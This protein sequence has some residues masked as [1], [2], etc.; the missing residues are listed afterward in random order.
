MAID[1]SPGQLAAM[2]SIKKRICS[3][4][5]TTVSGRAGA[6]VGGVAGVSGWEN[7]DVPG[8]EV[9]GVAGGG[10]EAGGMP[11]VFW[12]IAGEVGWA[13]GCADAKCGITQT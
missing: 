8:L 4:A 7:A 5:A 2:S 12:A 3:I 1:S 10:G 13:M 6:S 9:F 11:G